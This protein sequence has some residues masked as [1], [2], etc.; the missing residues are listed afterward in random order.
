MQM[1]LAAQAQLC[2]LLHL[3]MSLI[4]IHIATQ[5]FIFNT[6][7]KGVLLQTLTVLL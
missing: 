7:A 1:L 5:V 4:I 3:E 6:D 2:V